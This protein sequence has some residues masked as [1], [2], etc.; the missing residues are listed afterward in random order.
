MVATPWSCT[1]LE[2]AELCGCNN[3]KRGDVETK[4]EEN[5]R[6]RCFTLFVLYSLDGSSTWEV[7]EEVDGEGEAGGL[8]VEHG[9]LRVT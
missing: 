1:M 7:V 5:V 9:K 3:Q 4:E 6:N 2:N 8:R